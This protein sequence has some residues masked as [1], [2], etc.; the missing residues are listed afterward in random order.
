MSLCSYRK[1]NRNFSFKQKFSEELDRIRNERE[2]LE[3]ELEA[4]RGKNKAPD[5]GYKELENRWKLATTE[6]AKLSFQVK[7]LRGENEMLTA[8]QKEYQER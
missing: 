8:K 4:E 1:C 5:L 3:K 7:T 2:E 6:S